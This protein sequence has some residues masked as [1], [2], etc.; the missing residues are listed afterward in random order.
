MIKKCLFP[1]AGY[2]TRFLPA[3]KSMPKE[4]M[5]IVNK[6]L[7]EY[8]VEEAIE[9]GMNG[10]C[11][12]TGRGKNTLMDHFDKNYELEHQISGTNKEE[13]LFDIRRVI[14]SAHFTYIRQG[15]MKGLGHAIL[16]GRELVGNEP[17]AVVLADDLCVNEEQGVLAQMAALYKQFRCSIV[18]VEEVP[19]EDTHKYG[20]I[21]GQMIRDDLFR[22]DNMVEKPEPGTA[23]SNLA[24]IGRYILTPDI[25]DII[26]ETEPGKGGEIQ[27]TDALLKQAQSG[28]VL[29]FKF[30]GKR[31]DCGSVDGY[32]EAT[33]YCYEN[34]YKKE[35][36]LKLATQQTSKK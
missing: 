23:P 15:E 24:I 11:I 21:A 32:I 16:M 12:V 33:N 4:M 31:F 19:E 10:M 22:V 29:A 5:P 25:F 13:L 27:I 2:G 36:S 35:Q 34:V 28:C 26:E 1:A 3:T 9:A 20:V 17:F 18:A 30:K 6:P 8:G 7:I 14:D